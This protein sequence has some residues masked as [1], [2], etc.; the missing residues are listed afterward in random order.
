MKSVN[1]G[2]L[3]KAHHT[4]KLDPIALEAAVEEL[5]LDDEVTKK[6]GTSKR[7]ASNLLRSKTSRTEHHGRTV[8]LKWS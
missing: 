6:T 3:Y 8:V 1:W 2:I 5:M 7:P 4:E